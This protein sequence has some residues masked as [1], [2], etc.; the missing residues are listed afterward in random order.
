MMPFI[1]LL[2]AVRTQLG[3]ES[4]DSCRCCPLGS[5]VRR[6]KGG[7]LRGGVTKKGAGSTFYTPAPR[8]S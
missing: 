5:K 4:V 1:Y 8:R 3:L 6:V 7:K 2:P